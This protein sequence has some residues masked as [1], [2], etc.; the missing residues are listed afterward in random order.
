[1]RI[2]WQM[3]LNSNIVALIEGIEVGK[4]DNEWFIIIKRN[5]AYISL[6]DIENF[7]S[8]L[9]LLNSSDLSMLKKLNFPL[10]DLLT[11][12]L[13]SNSEYWI[14]KA[15][16][17]IIPLQLHRF[18]EELNN[19]ENDRNF[20]QKIRHLAKKLKYQKNE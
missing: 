7:I 19:I 10:S 16:N 15:L 5:N 20:S 9:P 6:N 18:K 3:E 4:S 2:F 13:T 12:A 17:Q 11:L 1:M 14:D 8:A